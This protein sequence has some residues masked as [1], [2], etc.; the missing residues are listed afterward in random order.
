MLSSNELIIVF[1]CVAVVFMVGW[2]ISIYRGYMLIKTMDERAIDENEVNVNYVHN[3]YS[4]V[5]DKI[6]MINNRVVSIYNDVGNVLLPSAY[7]LDKHLMEIKETV[8]EAENDTK[9]LRAVSNAQ[10]SKLLRMHEALNKNEVAM[11]HILEFVHIMA[12]YKL[13]DELQRIKNEQ[14][15][16]DLF[17][18]KNTVV[19]ADNNDAGMYTESE[20]DIEKNF[21]D[22]MDF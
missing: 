11:G 18:T 21:K 5:Y 19:D 8:E 17:A 16:E 20:M 2:S 10:S 3:L 7:S 9:T 14:P 22:Q 4:N 1:M 13:R 6:D 15:P 12:S